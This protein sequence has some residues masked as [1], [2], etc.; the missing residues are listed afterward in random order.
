M[1]SKAHNAPNV[2]V[3]KTKA[4]TIIGAGNMGTSLLGG[5][6]SKQYD[7]KKITLTSTSADKLKQIHNKFGVQTSTNNITS[8]TTADIVIFAIKPQIFSKVAL[9]L[10]TAVQQKKPLI[11]SVATGITESSIQQWLGGG[12]S[13]IRSM[14]NTPVVI[15]CGAT[16][17][18]ANN[19]V[20]QNQKQW[21]DSILS[22]VGITLWLDQE[23]LID[24]V[25]ALSGS[26]PAYFFLIMEA[27]QQAGEKLGL[28]AET[29]RILTL[30]TA[31]GAAR[32]A[33]ESEK[34]IVELRAA[35][36]SPHGTTE[37]AIKVLEKAKIRE[38]MADTL[39]AAQKR[40]K[41]LSKEL[42]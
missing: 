13:I 11:I 29:A 14:P 31:Y 32:L 2:S 17:L 19:Y 12:I 39:V 6:I 15:G 41:E 25:T 20:T 28:P 16:A 38:I 26:G 23:N 34:N 1:N 21:A 9:E 22:A 5:L 30:Q 37:Q 36:T 27:L 33:L 4:I 24:V 8:I 18:F 3:E 7:P 10:T 40:A 35:V 42:K